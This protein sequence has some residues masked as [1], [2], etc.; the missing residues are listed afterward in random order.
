VTQFL[1]KNKQ[2]RFALGLLVIAALAWLLVGL[3]SIKTDADFGSVDTVGWYAI[4]EKH[5]RGS[6]VVVYKP[7][8]T[9]LSSPDFP[10][11][12]TDHQPT[13]S[14]DGQR[15]YFISNR[16]TKHHNIYRWNLARNIVE[17]R[18]YNNRPKESLDFGLNDHPNANKTALVVSGAQVLE[19]NA[20]DGS[21]KQLLPSAIGEPN[22]V[23]QGLAFYSQLGNRVL[24]ALWGPGRREIFA[25]LKDDLGHEVVIC[26]K[27]GSSDVPLVL[28]KGN[29]F[30]MDRDV[31]GQV[32]C[33]VGLKHE[34]SN[35]NPI[36]S[37]QK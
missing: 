22:D 5:S 18:T 2:F 11:G 3:R 29:H 35:T 34:L 21:M 28:A 27:I 12:A 24:K 20:Q 17:Q 9:K 7:D 37:P 16:K 8:G 6:Q 19:F 33:K 15:L 14:P 31:H 13:W 25:M 23:A 32:V 26:Q 30:V 36:I 1:N 4:I 10:S